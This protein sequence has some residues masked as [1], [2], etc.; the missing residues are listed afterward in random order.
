LDGI[1]RDLEVAA[2]PIAGLDGGFLGAA[3]L[4]WELSE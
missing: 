2:V 4:F 3:A 1:A